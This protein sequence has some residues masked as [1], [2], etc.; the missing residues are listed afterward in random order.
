MNVASRVSLQRHE[1]AVAAADSLRVS[2][3]FEREVVIA[4]A[5]VRLGSSM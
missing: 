5:F 3:G 4:G 2:D 1:L